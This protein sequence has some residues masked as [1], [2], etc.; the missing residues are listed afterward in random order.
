MPGMS[1]LDQDKYSPRF[2]RLPG[3]IR[4][5]RI[6]GA[7]I[8]LHWS[9]VAGGLVLSAAGAFRRELLV[10]LVVA[11]LLV[12]L[13]HEIGHAVAARVLGLKVY[14]IR[15]MGLGGYCLTEPALGPRRICVLYSGGMIAQ[16]ISFF[17]ALF[18]HAMSSGPEGPVLG[19]FIVAFTFGNAIVFAYSLLPSTYRGQPSDGRVLLQLAIDR[20]H[21]R[22]VFYAGMPVMNSPAESPVFSPETSLLTIPAL[23]PQSFRDG[24]EI[25]NDNHTP[26][27]FV[28]D[29]L[30][31]H[32]GR[33]AHEAFVEMLRIHNRGGV[34]LPLASFEDAE[35]TASAI[36]AEADAAGHRFVCRAV[37]TRLIPSEAENAIASGVQQASAR[38]SSSSQAD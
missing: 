31:R 32:L 21:G 36:A 17:A 26:M 19:S 5:A 7:P 18:V 12:V 9:C 29:V 3:F 11:Y 15:L 25:L 13:T 24:V 4:V 6:G 33:D 16:L 2:P 28:M 1:D 37:S 35:R 34:L 27:Q 38:L 8:D 10:P 20:W 23:R 22:T 14:G 30:Q